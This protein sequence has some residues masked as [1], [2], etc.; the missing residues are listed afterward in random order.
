MTIDDLNRAESDRYFAVALQRSGGQLGAFHHGREIA[1]VEDQP[2]VHFNRD[3]LNSSALFDL[4]ADPAAITLPDP[5]ERFVDS[6]HR[7]R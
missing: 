2:V 7:P 6:C 1:S 4:D 3:V 5:G